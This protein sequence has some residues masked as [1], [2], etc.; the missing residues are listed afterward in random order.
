MWLRF[1]SDYDFS[2]D[3]RGGRVTIAYKAG[4]TRNVTRECADRAIVA[5][6]CVRTTSPRT[7]EADHAEE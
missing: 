1:T 4:M 7:K 5:G 3:A 2:P 6:K